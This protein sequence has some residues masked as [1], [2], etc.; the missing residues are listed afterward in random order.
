M[1]NI[2]ADNRKYK[3][4]NNIRVVTYLASSSHSHIILL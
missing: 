1:I 3:S 2:D 4:L